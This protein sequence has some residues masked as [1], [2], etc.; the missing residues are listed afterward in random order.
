M[1]IDKQQAQIDKLNSSMLEIHELKT[2]LEHLKSL[3]KT[4]QQ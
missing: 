4:S 2:E 1:I 3:I